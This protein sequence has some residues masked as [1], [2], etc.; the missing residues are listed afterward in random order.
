MS[1]DI[2]T[3]S[4]I[5]GFLALI[6]GLSGIVYPISNGASSSIDVYEA[7]NTSSVEVTLAWVEIISLNETWQGTQFLVYSGHFE[8]SQAY[9]TIQICVTVD[10]QWAPPVYLRHAK[11]HM[12]I[13]DYYY[14]Y[15]TIGTNCKLSLNGTHKISVYACVGGGSLSAYCLYQTLTIMDTQ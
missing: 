5:V 14:S 6:I 3:V 9:T 13:C 7:S 1:D 10:D 15:Q 2:G 11:R 8:Y 4:L 12:G